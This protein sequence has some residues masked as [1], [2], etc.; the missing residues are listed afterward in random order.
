MA[1]GIPYIRSYLGERGRWFQEI[2]KEPHGAIHVGDRRIEVRA[3]PATDAASIEATSKTLE[4]KYRGDP[5]TPAMVRPEV[6]PTTL[7]LVPA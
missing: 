6:L 1:G 4:T 3:E 2:R 7:R 5:A